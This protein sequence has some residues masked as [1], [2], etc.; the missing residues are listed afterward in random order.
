[1]ESLPLT[2]GGMTRP[3]TR[4]SS[5]VGASPAEPLNVASSNVKLES[6]HPASPGDQ[7]PP[8]W[9]VGMIAFVVASDLAR[10]GANG[11]RGQTESSISPGLDRRQIKRTTCWRVELSP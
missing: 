9:S 4:T 5:N 3:T 7:G 6:D 1:M 11:P 10:A 8:S 2:R